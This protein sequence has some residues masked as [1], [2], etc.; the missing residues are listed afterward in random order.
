M[1][2]VMII[3]D[4][5]E[6]TRLLKMLLEL[7]AK[8]ELKTEFDETAYDLARENDFLKTAKISVDFLK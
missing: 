7:G 1:T 4:E 3:D 5:I 2:R 6:M 8:K